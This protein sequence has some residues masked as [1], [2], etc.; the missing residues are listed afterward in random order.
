MQEGLVA[1][2][3]IGAPAG[4]DRKP[5]FPALLWQSARAHGIFLQI[6]ILYFILVQLL[7]VFMPGFQARNAFDVLGFFALSTIPSLLLMLFFFKAGEMLIH[8]RPKRP[9][10]RLLGMMWGVLGN[11]YRMAAGLP[12]VLALLIFMYDFAMIKANITVFQPFAWDEAFDR[13]DRVLHFGVRPWELLHPVLGHAPVTFLI[14]L[15]YN[16]WFFVMQLFWVYFAFLVEPGR[17]RTQFFLSFMAVWLIGGGVLAAVFSSAGPCFFGEGRL[18]L[19]P[20][21]YAGLMSYLRE[22]NEYIPVW[23]IATQDILWSLREQQSAFGGVSAMPS[24]HNATALLF[25]LASKGLPLWIRRLLILHAALVF[26]GSVHLGWHYA[27]DAY[28]AWG[29]TL[30]VWWVV[31]PLSAWWEAGRPA[32]VFSS[33]FD[34]ERPAGRLP[35]YA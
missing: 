19:S 17:Q 14:N 26:L 35:G 2:G 24:M 23:A 21:P 6:A 33:A 12:M 34:A 15:N 1:E 25:V 13:W 10:L 11:R 29:V 30:L 8:E 9:A 20:D 31:K 28:L 27:V 16:L 22:V 5:G 32:R 4:Q 18:G 7:V 3:G